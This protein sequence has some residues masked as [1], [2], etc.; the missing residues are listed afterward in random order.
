[1]RKSKSEYGF[2]LIEIM[3]VLAV[4]TIVTGV[5]FSA[6]VQVQKRNQVEEQQVDTTQTAREMV[7][8]VARDIRSSGYPNSR[9]Y[10][11]S[12]GTTSNLLAA[13][14]VAVSKTGIILE[15]DL[16]NTGTIQSVRYTLTPDA[17]GN[18][19]CTF[20]R[21]GIDKVTGTAPESQGTNY[22]T[23]AD[24]VL[25]S[26]GGTGWTIAGTTPGGASNNTIYAVHKRDPIFRVFDI[27]GAE[28][29]LPDTLGS[30]GSAMT[31]ATNVKS[32]TVTVNVMAAQYDLDTKMRPVATLQTN[33]IV[34]NR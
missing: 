34:P 8:Q 27:N 11:N 4:L 15:G 3:V 9:M 19:P 26:I 7:D 24:G 32:V 17:G 10:A 16:D 33:V 1:M 20:Q 13:G 12:P 22:A 23:A 5:L 28:V 25:N 6:M 29:T 14:I 30:L 18:C 21:S 31:A 2:S